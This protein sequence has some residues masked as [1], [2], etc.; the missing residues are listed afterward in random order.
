M[1]PRQSLE[2]QIQ[3]F[4]YRALSGTICKIKAQKSQRFLKNKCSG[5]RLLG[6]FPNIFSLR[7]MGVAGGVCCAD[8]SETKVAVIF[9]IFSP[10]YSTIAE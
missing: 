7:I 2:R 1:C 4:D 8:E 3:Y 6:L 10:T 9:L 5:V